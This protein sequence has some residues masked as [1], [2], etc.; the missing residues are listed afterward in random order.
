MPLFRVTCGDI[1][2]SA[3]A[4]ERIWQNFLDMMHED[5]E[6][7]EFDEVKDHMDELAGLEINGRQIRNTLTTARQLAIYRKEKLSW[8]HLEQAIR[9]STDFSQYLKRV[10]GHTD[11]QWAKE[12]KIR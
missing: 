10:H 7:V 11:E 2:T 8:G 9:V 3:D 5:K 6:D 12:E 1:G 4:V